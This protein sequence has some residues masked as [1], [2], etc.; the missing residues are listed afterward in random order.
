[1][2]KHLARVIMGVLL[3]A[4]LAGA[5]LAQGPVEPQHS[6]AYWQASYWNNQVFSGAPAV[7]RA[8]PAIA[9]DWGYGSPDAA[10]PVDHFSARWTRYIDTPAGV[11]RFTSTSD[12]GMRVMVDGEVII[13]VWNDHAVQVVTADRALA[14]GHHQVVVEFYENTGQAVARL[15]WA[16]A[17]GGNV[18]RG[19]YFSNMVLAGPP[20]LVRDDPQIA[21]DWGYN[22]PAPGIV[23]AD[24]FSVRWT[25]TLNLP[26][27][28]YRFTVTAD[29][30]VR[31]WV[32]EHLLIEVWRDQAARSYS[33]D[34]YLAGGAVPVRMEY[35]D[36]LELATARLTWALQGGSGGAV[37]VDELDAGFTR[38]GAAAGWHVAYEG[39]AGQLLWTRNNDRSRPDYNW[40]NW[41][42]RLTAGRYEVFVYAPAR[43]GTT[44]SARYW[45]SHA[46]G[47]TLRVVDQAANAGRWV[48]L[49]TFRFKGSAGDYVSLSDVTYEPY[50]SQSIAF[51]AVKW[52]PR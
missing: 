12:D 9:F 13:N 6:D 44:R 11:Y 29:D 14:A 26:A 2:V 15:G 31:L 5:A 21:F 36:H 46:D 22:S 51:D 50:L 34:I 17:S 42:P 52:E 8:D 7:Q 33:G 37:V 38:G 39:H 25:Q 1:M 32:N 28:N 45:V 30:G 19:E 20:V 23:P 47:Y 48:S 10:I 27:G 43:Y 4:L 24:Q 18:W 16:L 41:Y 49:G 3:F 40:G 35:Y